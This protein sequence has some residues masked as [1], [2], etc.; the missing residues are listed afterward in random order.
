MRIHK[1]RLNHATNS[2]SSHSII[3]VDPDNVPV[4]DGRDGE[5]GWD[6]FTASSE[7]SKN[8]YFACI[9]RSA[10]SDSVG[11]DIA[12]IVTRD[13]CGEVDPGAYVDHQC[14]FGMPK[15]WNSNVVDLEFVREFREMFLRKGVVVLGGNDNEGTFHPLHDSGKKM[16]TGMSCLSGQSVCRKDAKGHWTLFCPE[17]GTKARVSLDDSPPPAHSTYPELIDVKI[18]DFCAKGCDYCYQQSTPKGSHADSFYLQRLAGACGTMKVFEVA[19]GGGEPTAHP[20]FIH[21]LELF[22]GSGV[23][24]SFSTRCLAWMKDQA[25]ARKI[26]DLCGSWALSADYATDILIARE[27]ASKAGIKMP[28]IHIVIGANPWEVTRELIDQCVELRLRMVLLG[29]KTVGLGN[30]YEE[31]DNS[32]WLNMVKSR[33]CTVSID[34]TLAAKFEKELEE[35]AIPQWLLERKE[36]CHSMY[37]DAVAGTMGPSSFC[38]KSEMEPCELSWYGENTSVKEALAKWSKGNVNPLKVIQ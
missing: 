16:N 6:H 10:L 21:T 20:D 2:S 7:Q 33:K 12:E 5:F 18:T 19:I 22:R 30:G 13:I 1:A 15:A 28:A 34:T 29:F 26:S 31:H 25:K 11:R 3:I 14:L 23:V 24:P 17:V 36:G 37:V 38:A 8:N 32:G 4:D 9:L 27:T 35:A